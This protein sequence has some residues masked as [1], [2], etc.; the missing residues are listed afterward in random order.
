MKY[1]NILAIQI[2]LLLSFFILSAM[3]QTG[4]KEFMDLYKNTGIQSDSVWTRKKAAAWFNGHDW[5][6]GLQLKPHK[7]IDQQEFAKQYHNNK[8][9]WD[10]AFSFLKENDLASL[11]LGK[12][13]IDGEN[14]YATVTEGPTKDFDKT[15]WESHRNYNDI[16]YVIKGKE[17]IGVAPVSLATVTKEYDS[18]KDLANY[19]AKGKYYITNPG[20][21]FIIFPEDAHRP[22]IKVEGYN[23]EKKIVIKIRKGI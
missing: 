13:Q 12:I 1:K 6:N 11:K 22:G 14:V 20:T 17:K 23:V 19:T 7:S 15:I 3:T 4:T 18:T 9:K 16:H 21:F 10:K 5:L 8:E 2:L